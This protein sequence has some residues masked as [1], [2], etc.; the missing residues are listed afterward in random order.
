LA[1][2]FEYLHLTG[3]GLS[4]ASLPALT[5]LLREGRLRHLGIN[6]DYAPLLLGPG[7]PP[8][9]AALATSRLRLLALDG[10]DLWSDVEAARAA[11]T[12][13]EG[14]PTLE[15]LYLWR[16]V[17][18][19]GAAAA[20]GAALGALAAA[21]SAL[22]MLDVGSCMLRDAAAGLFAGVAA[23]SRIQRL[24]AAHN[25]ISART[26]HDAVLPAVRANEHLVELS[27]EQYEVPELVE[28]ARL[29]R[30]RRRCN[31]P[32]ADTKHFGL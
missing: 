23:G 32:T 29:V 17:L 10:A 11:L 28:A 1:G 16:N 5:R 27:F 12:A 19:T 31:G 26:A 13:I 6:N 24:T 14:H 20:A 30:V 18:P 4:P 15:A 21:P 9:A 7:V 2:G 3:C 8:F 22:R 25:D